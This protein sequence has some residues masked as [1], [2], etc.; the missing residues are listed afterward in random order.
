MQS[1]NLKHANPTDANNVLADVLRPQMASEALELIEQ[2]KEI[3]MGT[4]YVFA[5]LRAV[6]NHKMRNVKLNCL[7]NKY[8][9]GW[10]AIKK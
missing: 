2:G 5:F 9:Q 10:T 1:Y 7:I 8:N 4:K 3:E 6:E